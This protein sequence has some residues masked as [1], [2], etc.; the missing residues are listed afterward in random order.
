MSR[1]D[2]LRSLRTSRQTADLRRRDKAPNGI[3]RAVFDA[4]FLGWPLSPET[5]AVGVGVPTR[6][7][8]VGDSTAEE[9]ELFVD[10]LRSSTMMTVSLTAARIRSPGMALECRRLRHLGM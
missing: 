5:V 8:G 7:S 2:S 3:S 6:A 1:R 4:E 9:M 10:C